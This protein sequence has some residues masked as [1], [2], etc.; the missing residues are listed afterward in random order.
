MDF[1]GSK[2]GDIKEIIIGYQKHRI[3]LINGHKANDKDIEC[4]I[5][6]IIKNDNYKYYYISDG[7]VLELNDRED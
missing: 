7:I 1:N 5:I 3:T 4:F 2:L 6:H